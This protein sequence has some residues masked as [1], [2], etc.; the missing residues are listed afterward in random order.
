MTSRDTYDVPSF[1]S[2]VAIS[3]HPAIPSVK[4]GKFPKLQPPLVKPK[5][6]KPD[7]HILY[8]QCE[9]LLKNSQAFKR[10]QSGEYKEAVDWWKQ[11]TGSEE[12]H[13]NLGLAYEKGWGT[14]RSL[15]KVRMHFQG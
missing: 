4:K 8:E 1:A 3:Y 9:A 15:L 14:K 10:V 13:F 5:Q 12:G 11:T 6:N 2:T 7:V